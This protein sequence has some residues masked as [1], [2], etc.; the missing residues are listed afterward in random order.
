MRIGLYITALGPGGA[1]RV[2]S[3]LSNILK[4]HGH[5]VYVIL[6]ETEN[7]AYPLDGT[8]IDLGI[9]SEKSFFKRIA[10]LVKRIRALKRIKKSKSLDAVVSRVKNP[11]AMPVVRQLVLPGN[12]W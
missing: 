3:R 8:L 11:Q 12:I 9:R 7:M 4:N 5:S 1:E 10:V 2:V 6:S